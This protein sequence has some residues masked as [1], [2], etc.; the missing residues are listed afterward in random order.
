MNKVIELLQSH[1]SIRKFQDREVDQSIVEE[2]VRAGQGAATSSFIQACT[3]IQVN[4]PQA[5]EKLYSAAA[6]QQ[7][8][9]E[10]PVFLVFCAD[11]QRHRLACDMHQADMLSGFTEQFLTASVDCALFAQNV[12]VGAE[13]LGLGGCYIGAIRNKIGEVDVLLDLPEL[14]Y[15]I[16]GMCIGY[17]AQDPEVKPRLP[18]EVVLKQEIY[19]DAGDRQLIESYDRRVQSY[20]RTRTG[21]QKDNSWSEQ[22]S[23]MLVKEARP[24]MLAF[25]RAKG[26][27]L[28]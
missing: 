21:G 24:H 26:F 7:Y 18:V 19:S 5:R 15:P 1:R 3:V 4:D 20:Y 2:L 11:M 8:V 12:L 6:G 25:L 9:K 16:F 14:V 17:P 10:A 28:K 13:S 23:G 22:I 27:L